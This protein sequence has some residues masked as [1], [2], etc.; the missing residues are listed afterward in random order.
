VSHIWICFGFGKIAT[1]RRRGAHIAN[2]V[3]RPRPRTGFGG[4]DVEHCLLLWWYVVGTD[5]ATDISLPVQWKWK[6]KKVDLS[7]IMSELKLSTLQ[8]FFG[9]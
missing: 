3:P 7:S 1:I 5:Q 8:G 9:G 6:K 4:G 2:F